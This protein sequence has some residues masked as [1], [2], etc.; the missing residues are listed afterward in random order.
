M[1]DIYMRRKKRARSK[2]GFGFVVLTV[3]VLFCVITYNKI[4]LDA[5]CRELSAQK[6]G[7]EKEL[8][9]LTKEQENIESYK[10]YVYS[11]ENIESIAREKLGLVYPDEIVFEAEDE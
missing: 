11:N 6:A 10:E 3:L 9:E 2:S 5:K 7:D 1:G 8:E 4:G